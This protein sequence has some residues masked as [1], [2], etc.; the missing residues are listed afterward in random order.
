MHKLKEKVKKERKRCETKKVEAQEKAT[1][2]RE[3]K[4]QSQ[5][6]PCGPVRKQKT[7]H[8]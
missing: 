6:P 3:A 5:S 7:A 2:A 8:S 1:R 4:A